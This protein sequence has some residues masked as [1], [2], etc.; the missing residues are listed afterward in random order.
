MYNYELSE[1]HFSRK[2]RERSEPGIKPRPQLKLRARSTASLSTSPR[3]TKGHLRRHH[4]H[5]REGRKVSSRTFKP[6]TRSWNMLS[7]WPSESVKRIS[8]RPPK[9]L[10]RR[11]M[12]GLNDND[13]DLGGFD[14]NVNP[15]DDKST[16]GDGRSLRQK[17]PSLQR[18]D[19]QHPPQRDSTRVVRLSDVHHWPDATVHQRTGGGPR[20]QPICC[21]VDHDEV[22]SDPTSSTIMLTR[23]TI[24]SSR[25]AVEFHWHQTLTWLG[26]NRTD[27]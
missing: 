24:S 17:S 10:P 27:G 11:R 5:R 9:P 4:R 14:N 3:H 20:L 8:W 13:L 16:F 15:D 7:E 19:V 22:D 21:R 6:K 12:V 18:S 26:R 2:R 1:S 23:R 25:R